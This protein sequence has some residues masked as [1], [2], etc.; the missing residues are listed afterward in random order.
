[1]VTRK[2]VRGLAGAP[3]LAEHNIH[4]DDITE[5]MRIF[6]GTPREAA[7]D[8]VKKYFNSNRPRGVAMYLFAVTRLTVLSCIS[9]RAAMSRRIS[10]RR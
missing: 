1:M 2:P 6:K 9:T 8:E 4:I 5:P 7:I 10:G 3:Y